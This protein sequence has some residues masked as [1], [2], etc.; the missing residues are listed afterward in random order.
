MSAAGLVSAYHAHRHVAQGAESDYTHY[1]TWK[2][3][4]PFHIDYVWLPQ[5]WSG[6]MSLN[7]GDYDTY[8]GGGLSDH[9]PVTAEFSIV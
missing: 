4:K 9:V 8:V 3:D 1:W 2:R 5:A 7:V 6:G